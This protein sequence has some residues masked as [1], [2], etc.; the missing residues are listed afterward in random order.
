MYQKKVFFP[1]SNK[2]NDGGLN[3]HRKSNLNLN[4]NSK[5]DQI[6][7][8]KKDTK[9]EKKISSKNLENNH[10]LLRNEKI[11][12]ELLNKKQEI[13]CKD[14]ICKDKD[15]KLKNDLVKDSDPKKNE[16]NLTNLE[17]RQNET[18]K[19]MKA[20][21][22]NL[23]ENLLSNEKQYWSK[24]SLKKHN[25]PHNIRAKMIDWMVEVMC[26]YK[27]ANTTF[28][29]AVHYLDQ[30]FKMSETTYDMSYWNLYMRSLS[31]QYEKNCFYN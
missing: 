9:I 26:S 11:K 7:G 20:Y 22:S 29:V 27:C 21:S 8:A 2:E 24:D 25:I 28:F 1:V 16:Q 13:A 23:V 6:L 18:Q 10:N 5:H 14:N 31:F 15:E 3:M 19:I 4:V 17:F 12:D 30:F